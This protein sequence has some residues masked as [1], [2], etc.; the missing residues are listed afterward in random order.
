MQEHGH[1]H[2]ALNLFLE[3]R[4]HAARSPRRSAAFCFLPSAFC[5]LSL[6]FSNINIPIE[7]SELNLRSAPVD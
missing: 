3:S 1:V 7:S 6:C 4:Q 2:K 5:L